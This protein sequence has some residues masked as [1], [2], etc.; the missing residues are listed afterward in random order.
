MVSLII[1]LANDHQKPTKDTHVSLV[2]LK[3]FLAVVGPW[4]WHAQTRLV[5]RVPLAQLLL[6]NLL[7]TV[8][9]KY[10]Y[11]TCNSTDRLFNA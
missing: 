7:H 6:L 9:S 3:N 8:H 10:L 1:T 11:D 5:L 4:K 2:G